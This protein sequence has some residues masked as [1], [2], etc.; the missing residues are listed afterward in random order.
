MKLEVD[1]VEVVQK[2]VLNGK[3]V[4][5]ICT[6]TISEFME[7]VEEAKKKERQKAIDLIEACDKF[8]TV[9]TS[10]DDAVTGPSKSYQYFCRLQDWFNQNEL[11]DIPTYI[12]KYGYNYFIRMLSDIKASMQNRTLDIDNLS[13]EQ[14]LQSESVKVYM[15]PTREV[16]RKE[17]NKEREDIPPI[18]PID[19]LFW[20]MLR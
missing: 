20:N 7:M 17:E 1:K 14:L 16:E 2:G 18:N 12:Q 9:I 3:S 8:D 15:V 13:Y 10:E 4:T 19:K 5:A 6:L 11:G